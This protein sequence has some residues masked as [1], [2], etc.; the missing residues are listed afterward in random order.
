LF[1]KKQGFIFAAIFSATIIALPHML[2]MMGYFPA[3]ESPYYLWAVFAPLFIAYM[4]L[5]VTYIIV[6]SQLG[7]VCDDHE[8][9]TRERGEGVVFSIR[10]FSMK[11]TMGL[12][13]MIGG[14]GLDIIKFPQDAVPG[15][16]GPEI[17]NGLLFMSGPLYL[18]FTALGGACMAFY[19]LSR[20][21]HETILEELEKRRAEE[22]GA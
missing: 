1:E 17:V 16:L 8:Y 6:D 11:A 18:I 20:A 21:R 15:E 22:S 14:Y 5:P 2:K 7:D 9:K 12:G 3:N 13:A 10:T 19:G 4:I